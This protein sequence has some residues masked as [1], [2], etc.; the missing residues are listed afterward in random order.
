VGVFAKNEAEK[1]AAV[2]PGATF[3]EKDGTI[4]N[5]QGKEQK[6]KRAIVPPG[7]SKLLSEILMLWANSKAG[8]A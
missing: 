7:Q 1:F 2:L 6:L 3:A 5:V 4:V 8:A